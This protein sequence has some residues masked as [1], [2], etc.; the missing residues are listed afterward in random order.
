M[1]HGARRF[2]KNSE[3]VRHFRLLP[4]SGHDKEG[5]DPDASPLVLEPFVPSRNKKGG[6]WTDEAELLQIPECLQSLGPETF[7]LETRGGAPKEGSSGDEEDGEEE[8]HDED[9]ELD[10][11]CYFPKDGYNYNQHLKLLSTD[12]QKVG[13]VVLD[14]P[15]QKLKSLEM[16]QIVTEEDLYFQQPA[17][18]EEKEVMQALR[19]ADLYE[20]LDDDDFAELMPGGALDNEVLLWGP[21]ALENEDLPDLAIFKAMHAERL[22]AMAG[23]TAGDEDGSDDGAGPG[24]SGDTVSAS[25]FEQLLEDEYGDDETGALDDDEIEGPMNM[26]NMEAILDEFLQDQQAEK[27]FLESI[28]EPQ[29][30]I[31][32]KLD[33][34]PRVIEETKAIIERHY[35]ND[36]DGEADTSE[37]ESEEDESKNW[38][39]ETVLSTLS[40]VS[41]RPGKIGKIKLVKK[42]TAANKD[43]PAITESGSDAEDEDKEDDTVELPDV[44]TE[45]PRG[46]SSEDK[47]QR[48]AAV[49][50][51]RRICRRMK[52]ESKEMY[53]Q[54]AAKLSSS[55][56]GNG[57]VREKLRCVKL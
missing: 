17:N 10:G 35:L 15:K 36:D 43:L 30:A 28:A 27:Q 33:S 18:Q 42:A 6:V 55:A 51:M 40:N 4:R 34:V 22:A 48:K 57:D 39:C 14:A 37:G 3:N 23:E 29:E 32:R 8:D 38:D 52:K 9:A 25:R 12:K 41:N 19:E 13:G 46:E 21:T 50:E 49:K 20:E 2:A 1:P 24:Q 54:E 26:E 53:K 5:E 7:G 56:K 16:P 11:D 44:V 31:C 45:R 47:K